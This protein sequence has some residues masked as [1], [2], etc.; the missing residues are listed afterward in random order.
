MAIADVELT[1]RTAGRVSS[2]TEAENYSTLVSH[3]VPA[4]GNGKGGSPE[5]MATLISVSLN[6][7]C[8]VPSCLVFLVRSYPQPSIPQAPLVLRSSQLWIIDMSAPRML[9]RMIAQRDQC[10]CGL[11]PPCTNAFK[12]ATRV[13]DKTWESRVSD[14][15]ILLPTCRSRS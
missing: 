13:V 10:L 2:A 3:T 5:N 8:R 11:S 6:G 7:Y 12:K 4:L 15:D 14:T 9:R 1:C